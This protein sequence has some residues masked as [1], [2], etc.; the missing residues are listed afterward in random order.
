MVTI[1]AT[2]LDCT[3]LHQI[4]VPADIRIALS[5]NFLGV[6]LT[7]E[8][9]QSRPG[10]RNPTHIAVR[11]ARQAIAKRMLGTSQQCQLGPKG[12]SILIQ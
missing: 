8:H 9:L 3:I 4:K 6:R 11:Q 7:R 10:P 2:G 12:G 1:V 5:R